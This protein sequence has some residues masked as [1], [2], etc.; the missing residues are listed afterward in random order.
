MPERSGSARKRFAYTYIYRSLSHESATHSGGYE[1]I[2]AVRS[3]DRGNKAADELRAQYPNSILSVMEC[4]LGSLKS[5]KAFAEKVVAE[6]K[7]L[8]LLL[9]N[10]GLALGSGVRQFAQASSACEY[11]T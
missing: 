10:A 3:L 7:A 5:I 4:D 6:K 8:H 1:L 9:L 2:L 11:D